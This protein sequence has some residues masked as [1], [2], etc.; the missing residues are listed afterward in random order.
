MFITE[1]KGGGDPVS[2]FKKFSIKITFLSGY[3]LIMLYAQLH[4]QLSNHELAGA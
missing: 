3:K 1:P 4:H 2:V